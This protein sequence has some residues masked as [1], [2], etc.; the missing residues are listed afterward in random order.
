ML[1]STREF[2]WQVVLNSYYLEP[3]PMPVTPLSRQG[4]CLPPLSICILQV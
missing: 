4:W 2:S 1:D 3:L